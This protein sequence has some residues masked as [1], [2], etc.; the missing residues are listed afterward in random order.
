MNPP[1]DDIK[2]ILVTEDLDLVAGTNL[3]VGKEPANP[4]NTVTIFDSPGG[5]PGRTYNRLEKYEY[6]AVN[7]RVR[8][9]S[10]QLGM[11]QAQDIVNALEGLSNIETD[12]ALYT[13]IEVI[14]GPGLVGYDDNGRPWITFNLE[15]QRRPIQVET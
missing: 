9:A 1:S 4:P 11:K 5:G 15:I 8:N 13:R 7:I 10:Y 14:D 2:D 12:K 3:F 6:R